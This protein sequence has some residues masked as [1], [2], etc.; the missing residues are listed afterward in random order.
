[1]RAVKFSPQFPMN[2]PD[3]QTIMAPLLAFMASGKV[4]AN[5]DINAA[6][7]SH[8]RLNEED[9]SQLL[10]SG[11]QS[12]FT[13]RVAWAKSHLKN[14]ELLTSPGR[15]FYQITK[16]GLD[17]LRESPDRI[18]MNYLM[19][20]PEFR[21][22]REKRK[23]DE[24]KNSEDN[25]FEK[26][27]E[28]YIELGHQKILE[29]L[30]QDILLKIKSCSP[31]FFEKLVIDVLLAIGY[32]GSRR[33]AGRIVG[34]PGDGGIDGIIKEDKLGLDTIYVQAKRWDSTIGRPQIQQFAGALQG[35]KA[36]KGIFISTSDF[37]Q[38]AKSYTDSIDIKIIL[39]DGEGLANLMIEHNVGVS[40]IQT[41]VVKRVD[42][43]YFIED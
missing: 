6:L 1:M 3:F 34:K 32:G 25:S 31:K 28:E 24:P 30:T 2:I 14:A 23:Q 11:R 4:C 29:S 26:T 43:D 17:A 36:K 35:K 16:R 40:H 41:Y 38:E 15:G 22:F 20:F 10:P 27:P 39:I 18:D 19:K 7:A 33:E 5:Q 21:A 13:N 8:F 42:S 9:L 37:S 12:V